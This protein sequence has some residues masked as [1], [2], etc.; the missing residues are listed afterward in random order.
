MSPELFVVAGPNGSGKSSSITSSGLD[1]HCP[2]LLNPDNFVRCLNDKENE[3][4]RYILAIKICEKLRNLLLD[5]GIEFGF[6]TVGSTE[7][8]LEFIRNAK[9]R[10]YTVSFVFVNAGSPEMCMERIKARVA[11]GGHD[12]PED[13][14]RSR[15]ARV[16]TLLPEYIRMADNAAVYDNSGENAELVMTKMDGEIRV[17][18]NTPD[19]LRPAVSELTL[20]THGG[21]HGTHPS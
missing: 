9:S 15:Y 6:E 8:K 2:F 12:V 7:E 21:L 13:K 1:R 20:G 4:K 11:S 18:G 17:I 3:Y 10:G 14:V 16:L 5:F 19:W